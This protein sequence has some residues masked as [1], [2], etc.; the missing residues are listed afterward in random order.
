MRVAAERQPCEAPEHGEQRRRTE[1][2]DHGISLPPC[3]NGTVTAVAG[4]F[5]V[6]LV[7]GLLVLLGIVLVWTTVVFWRGSTEDHEVLAPLEV[8][9]DRRFGRL[10]DSDKLALLNDVRPAGAAPVAQYA[11]NE[12]VTVDD[13]GARVVDRTED[14]DHRYRRFSDLERLAPSPPGGV[15]RPGRRRQHDVFDDETAE[16]SGGID[17]DDTQD[18]PRRRPRRDDTGS[19]VDESRPSARPPRGDRVRRRPPQRRADPDDGQWIDPLLQ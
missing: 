10:D 16:D 3:E 19:T 8:M 14:F 18:T 1:E 7:G 13:S 12:V 6:D 4:S 17:R 2:V 5:T 11:R 15:R 9:G